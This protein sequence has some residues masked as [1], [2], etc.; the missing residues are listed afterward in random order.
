MDT[1]KNLLLSHYFIMSFNYFHMV[2]T[3]M[4]NHTTIIIQNKLLKVINNVS[5]TEL[6][7]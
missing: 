7:Q 3:H 2:N 1:Y 6:E 5:V 4:S